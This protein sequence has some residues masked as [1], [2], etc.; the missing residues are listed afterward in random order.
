MTGHATVERVSE[1]DV[2]QQARERIA[3]LKAAIAAN[4]QSAAAVAGGAVLALL[5][6]QRARRS[7]RS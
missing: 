3:Q 6:L 2:Q 1:P 7:R 5:I 4:K